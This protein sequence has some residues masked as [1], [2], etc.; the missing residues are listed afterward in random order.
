MLISY[1]SLSANCFLSDF[2]KHRRLAG[3][4]Y[5][6]TMYIII[7]YSLII[8]ST[9]STEDSQVFRT[10]DKDAVT[11]A[12]VHQKVNKSHRYVLILV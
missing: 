4:K 11:V 2:V 3:Y 1:G 9:V 7:I 6:Y 8:Y 12:V 10:D 5:N